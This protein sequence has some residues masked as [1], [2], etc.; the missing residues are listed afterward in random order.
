MARADRLL[1]TR[2]HLQPAGD[3][4][5]PHIDPSVWH[6]VE[7]SEWRAGPDDEADFTVIAYVRAAAGEATGAP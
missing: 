4:K 5:F 1:I 7:R 2:V 3:T 6:E